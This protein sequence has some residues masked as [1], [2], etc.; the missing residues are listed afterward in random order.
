[1]AL[2]KSPEPTGS[3]CPHG[4]GPGGLIRWQQPRPAAGGEF[5]LVD[6]THPCPGGCAP[7]WHY[8]AAEQ[9]RVVDPAADGAA[10]P[11]APTRAAGHADGANRLPDTFAALLREAYRRS[12]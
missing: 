7:E 3:A 12:R 6:M 9:A 11:T 1:M 4:C 10:A 8:P 2:D 5:V